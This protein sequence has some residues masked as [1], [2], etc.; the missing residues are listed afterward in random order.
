MEILPRLPMVAEH[1]TPDRDP[2]VICG[3]GAGFATR[4]QIL[5]RIEAEG[6]GPAHRPGLSPAALLPGEVL[7]SVGLA[8]VFD[9]DK[10][11]PRCQVEY[12]V[13][14]CHLAIQMDRHDCCHRTSGAF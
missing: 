6:G 11:E 2:F 12:R 13:H 5:T 3:D 1:L 9:D 7:G 14:V 10:V 8:G 4:P